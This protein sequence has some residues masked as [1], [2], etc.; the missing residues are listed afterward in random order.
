MVARKDGKILQ[1]ASMVGIA[2]SPLMA[3]YAGTKA[4]VYNFT[5]SIINEL[6]DS[7]VTVTAL[8]PGATDTD[9][10]NKADAENT[11]IVQDGDL[12]DP[13]DVAKDGYDALMKGESKVVSGFKNKVMAAMTNIM[14]EQMVAD[15]M[16]KQNEEVSN[17]E[18]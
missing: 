10:F 11:K 8:L 16:H 7:G 17:K 9:F 13:A 1:L 2:P 6:K 14:P 12:A 15:S 5:Q 4:Y 18:Q 3:V